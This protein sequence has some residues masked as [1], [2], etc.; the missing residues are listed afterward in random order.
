MKYIVTLLLALMVSCLLSA[1]GFPKAEK[2]PKLKEQR[3]NQNKYKRWSHRRHVKRGTVYLVPG[4]L[5]MQTPVCILTGKK[6]LVNM[7]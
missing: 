6:A 4:I 2:Q 3:G 7:A 5:D 1:Q